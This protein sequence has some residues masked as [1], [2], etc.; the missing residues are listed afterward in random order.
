MCHLKY[1]VPSEGILLVNKE[2][3]KVL[4][5]DGLVLTSGNMS[6]SEVGFGLTHD[7]HE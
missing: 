5:G 4:E 6:G 7:V 2:V 1:V 3:K